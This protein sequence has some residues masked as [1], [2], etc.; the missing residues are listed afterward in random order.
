MSHQIHD[1][2]ESIQR[3]RG[4]LRA[5]FSQLKIA[6]VVVD[7]QNDFVSGSLSIKVRLWV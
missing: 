1:S 3:F 4:E 5:F 2:L 6:L 7:F